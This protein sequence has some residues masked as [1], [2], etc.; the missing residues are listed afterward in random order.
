MIYEYALSPS[1]PGAD[2]CDCTRDARTASNGLGLLRASGQIYNEAIPFLYA[3]D[4][5]SIICGYINVALEHEQHG[6]TLVKWIDPVLCRH[7][8]LD[9]VDIDC[10]PHN[11]L[12]L[13]K[14]LKVDFVNL[15]LQYEDKD[16]WDF[17]SCTAKF[18]RVIQQ[19]CTILKYCVQLQYL[20]IDLSFTCTLGDIELMASLI[21]PIKLLRGIKEPSVTIFGFQYDRY[22]NEYG[23]EPRWHLTDEFEDYL[24]HLLMSPHGTPT[25]PS[26]GIK[27]F[28][29]SWEM[30]DLDLPGCVKEKMNRDESEKAVANNDAELIPNYLRDV[31][32][33]DDLEALH[34]GLPDRWQIWL[35][36]EVRDLSMQ[37]MLKISNADKAQA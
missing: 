18:L 36:S 22:F 28:H 7:T 11:A 26:N 17:V 23:G 8:N 14:N 1:S 3:S 9:R 27:I 13:I 20:E 37:S 34:G 4:F 35:Q 30:S 19:V 24:E 6:M 12:Q 10:V 29:D 16:D 25:P 33:T 2:S 15:A 31:Y 21:E 32:G 5:F